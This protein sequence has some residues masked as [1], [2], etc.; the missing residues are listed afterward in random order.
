MHETETQS[1]NSFACFFVV[2]NRGIPTARKSTAHLDAAIRCSSKNDTFYKIFTKCGIAIA[3]FS[4][5]LIFQK[6]KLAHQYTTF[7]MFL[8]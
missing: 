7:L 8:L 4:Q 5:I 2:K 3:S 6:P 1:V